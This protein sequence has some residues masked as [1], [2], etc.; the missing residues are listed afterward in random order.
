MP[1]AGRRFTEVL[2][3]RPREG[4]DFGKSTSRRDLGD[5]EMTVGQQLPGTFEAQGPVMA[6]GRGAEVPAKQP[7]ER[8]RRGADGCGQISQG[9]RILDV[10]EHPVHRTGEH[11]VGARSRGE[12]YA[13]IRAGPGV[14]QHLGNAVGKGRPFD[15]RHELEHHVDG[16]DATRTGKP[17]PVE[18]ECAVREF[19]DAKPPCPDRVYRLPTARSVAPHLPENPS[20]IGAQISAWSALPSSLLFFFV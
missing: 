3:E 2:C 18:H 7:A 20:R 17:S 19:G 1:R 16:G 14:V 9:Q 10:C 4:R 8:P 11:R 15:A 13:C 6:H 12:W 5:G